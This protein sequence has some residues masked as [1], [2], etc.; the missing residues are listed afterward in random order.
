MDLIDPTASRGYTLHTTWIVI[1]DICGKHDLKYTHVRS[2]ILE[3]RDDSK[4]LSQAGVTLCK[5]NI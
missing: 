2:E 1:K 3:M 4:D 5:S